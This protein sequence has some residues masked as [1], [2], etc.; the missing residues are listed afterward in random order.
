MDPRGCAGADRR[1]THGVSVCRPGVGEKDSQLTTVTTLEHW[2]L[3]ADRELR[4][5]WP[6]PRQLKG[7]NDIQPGRQ[8][9]LGDK[10]E[11]DWEGKGVGLNLDMG[12]HSLIIVYVFHIHAHIWTSW[13]ILYTVNNICKFYNLQFIIYY[14]FFGFE[15][16]LGSLIFLPTSCMIK[17]DKGDFYEHFLNSLK[18]GYSI[19]GPLDEP[20]P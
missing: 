1:L 6:T 13:N 11:G 8:S 12:S 7:I 9:A 20:G 15:L 2:S 18:Q 5:A 16:R 17:K 19:G 14:Y 4:G 3:R 10:R